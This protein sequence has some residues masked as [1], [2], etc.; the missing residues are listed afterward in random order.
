LEEFYSW[1]QWHTD[2]PH[3]HHPVLMAAADHETAGEIWSV[4]MD[5]WEE[6]DE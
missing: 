3:T 5:R 1:L 2:H 4:K 6:T